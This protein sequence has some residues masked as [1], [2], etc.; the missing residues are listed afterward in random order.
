MASCQR[1]KALKE[2]ILGTRAEAPPL[3]G[4]REAAIGSQHPVS[5]AERLD[6]PG[7]SALKRAAGAGYEGIVAKKLTSFYEPRRSR[8]WLKIK[9]V[10]QQELV[11]IG[12]NPSAHS[13]R[14]VGSL[15]LAVNG[16]DG[17]LHYAGKVGTGFSAKQ[18]VWLKDELSKDVIPQSPAKDA[19]RI[20]VATWVRPR[21]VAE[22]AFTEWTGDSRLRHPSFLGLRE[23]KAPDEVVREKPI[24][25]QRAVARRGR[26]PLG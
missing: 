16:P 21:L 14:E 25:G 12:W 24:S 17:Q 18:R 26:C 20:K 1:R 2:E 4:N 23:D 10:N 6:G 9:A 13:S 22:V 19:P 3:A 15:H 5:L 11:I 8:E 7:K